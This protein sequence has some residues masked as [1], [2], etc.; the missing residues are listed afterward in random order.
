[1]ASMLRALS[2]LRVRGTV[3]AAASGVGFA[4]YCGARLTSAPQCDAG[5]QPPAAEGAAQPASQPSAPPVWE[6]IT[7]PLQSALDTVKE[8]VNDNLIAPFTEPSS[9]KLLPD[10]PARL[11]GKELP[12]LVIALDDVILNSTWDRQYGWRYMKR[13]GVDEFLQA[14]APYYEV[15]VWTEQFS[16]MEPVITTLDRHRAVRHRLYKDSM[17]YRQ[18]RHL[19]DLEHLNRPLS[20]TVV[21]D[22]KPANAVQQPANYIFV[23]P[24]TGS[25]SGADGASGE[26]AAAKAPANAA[27]DDELVRHVPF[28]LNLARLAFI[29]GV[30]VRCAHE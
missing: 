27:K 18:G 19:K 8:T 16:M 30:D 24:F 26:G 12:T 11:R 3:A 5:S 4:A 22:C 13:P 25:E 7:A 15:V 29:K 20:K 17:V 9:Q 23:T 28:L 21:I 14:V 2:R 6:A 10:L 1:M